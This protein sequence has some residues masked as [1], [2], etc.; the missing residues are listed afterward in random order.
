[1]KILNKKLIKIKIK[2]LIINM[3]NQELVNEIWSKYDKDGN[4]HLD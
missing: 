4:G 1:M 3:S 2:N